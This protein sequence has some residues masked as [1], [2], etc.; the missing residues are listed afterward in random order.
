MKST[1]I[2][3]RA[4]ERAGGIFNARLRREWAAQGHHL[5]GAWEQSLTTVATDAGAVATANCYGGIVNSGVPAKR[6]PYG[7]RSGHEGNSK[8]ITG[9]L[10]YFKLR[11]LPEKEALRATFATAAKH[12]K[13]GMP[14]HASLQYSSTG[15]RLR[16]IQT[17]LDN[18]PD[19]DAAICTAFDEIID[20]AMQ[21]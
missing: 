3:R 8:Y 4:F 1:N 9:L 12:K 21:E 13:E 2:L 18:A 17:A 20:N 6:I 10:N 14:T 11:G 19:A 5:T 16:F 15:S 7:G